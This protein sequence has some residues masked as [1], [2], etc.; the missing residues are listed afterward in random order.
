[1]TKTMYINLVQQDFVRNMAYTLCSVSWKQ[2]QNVLF[3][4][5]SYIKSTVNTTQLLFLTCT[6]IVPTAFQ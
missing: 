6:N 5:G 3:E 2:F 1:M 4:V